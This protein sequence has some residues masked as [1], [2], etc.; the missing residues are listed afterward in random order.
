MLLLLATAAG[1]LLGSIPVGYL[2]GRL[3]GID[4]RR[5][6]SGATGGTNVLRT[7]GWGPAL[8]TLAGDLLKGTLAAYLGGRL[9]G[10]WGYALAGLAAVVGHSYPVWLGFR[11]GKS[12]ATGM[13]T[14]VPAHPQAVLT[15]LAVGVALIAPTR[16]VS[17]GSMGG[18]L[19]VLLYML[20][21]PAP[22]AH[23][24]LAAGA[25]AVVLWRH[26]DNMRRLLAGKEHK[27][28]Q[29]AGPG[30]GGR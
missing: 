5:Y 3:R 9:A 4:V 7:L 27:L 15:G 11:G 23:K 13:G 21:A 14:L 6:G 16:Y 26:R 28:G 12:V 20:L 17:L 18:A 2:V 19:A 30:A 29:K 22:A 1:Y 25:V 8:V 10:D 24:F